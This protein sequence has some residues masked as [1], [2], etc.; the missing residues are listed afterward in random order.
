MFTVVVAGRLWVFEMPA[1][2]IPEIDTF[3]Q[4]ADDR[5]IIVAVFGFLVVFMGIWFW[6]RLSV[7]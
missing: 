3:G 1:R 7:M 5:D 4:V 2:V 6:R